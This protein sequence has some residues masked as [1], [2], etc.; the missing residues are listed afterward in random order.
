MRCSKVKSIETAEIQIAHVAQPDLFTAPHLAILLFTT[1][2]DRRM[3]NIVVPV[4][5]SH[6]TKH[7]GLENSILSG[8][9]QG[10]TRTSAGFEYKILTGTFF[11]VTIATA[12]FPRTAM[13]VIPEDFAALKAYSAGPGT[14]SDRF[15]KFPVRTPHCRFCSSLDIDSIYLMCFV[16]E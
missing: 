5:P 8:T 13:L 4:F 10:L 3:Q 6:H 2:L 11:C 12:S 14:A 15:P 16:T 7:R 9:S 1:Q